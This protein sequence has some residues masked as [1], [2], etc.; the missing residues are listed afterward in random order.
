MKCSASAS[1]AQLKLPCLNHK[2]FSAAFAG[3]VLSAFMKMSV[4][5]LV[6]IE[7]ACPASQNLC[8]MLRCM[9]LLVCT[10][11]FSSPMHPCFLKA[12]QWFHRENQSSQMHCEIAKMRSPERNSS[13]TAE[14][15]KTFRTVP[16]ALCH[17]FCLFFLYS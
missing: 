11:A 10:P 2:I 14:L 16:R 5:C 17:T 13:A 7:W 4:C 1:L 15:C 3:S 12:R 6:L 9:M 8:L